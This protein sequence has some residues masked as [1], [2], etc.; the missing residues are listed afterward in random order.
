MPEASAYNCIWNK[1][2]LGKGIGGVHRNHDW[3]FRK[4]CLCLLVSFTTIPSQPHP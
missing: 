1:T 2:H 3:S 4:V